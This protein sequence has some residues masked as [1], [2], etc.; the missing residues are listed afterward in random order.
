MVEYDE[1]QI[2]SLTGELEE[3]EHRALEPDRSRISLFATIGVL[4]VTILATL[5]A[6]IAA[7]FAYDEAIANRNRQL[8]D[9]YSLARTVQEDSTS[10]NMLDAGNAQSAAYWRAV[11]TETLAAGASTSAERSALQLQATSYAHDANESQPPRPIEPVHAVMPGGN[12]CSRFK[13]PGSGVGQ[14]GTQ[15]DC[16]AE[17]AAAY[18]ETA[19]GFLRNE[20]TFL[21]IASA[22]AISLFLFALS[23]TLLIVPMQVMFLCVGALT[24]LGS[25][26]IGV[27]ELAWRTASQPD[28]A[29]ISAYEN[30][31]FAQAVQLDPGYVDA[32]VG[33]SQFANDCTHAVQAAVEAE[34]LS[35]TNINKSD[36]ATTEMN[37][38]HLKS[39]RTQ[40]LAA[41]RD[42]AAKSDPWPF[43]SAVE[44]LL[45]NGDPKL[46]DQAL[47]QAIHY[48][49][50]ISATNGTKQ[51]GWVYEDLWFSSLLSNPID[52]LQPKW[53]PPFI[54]RV[55][56]AEAALAE[57]E[58]EPNTKLSGRPLTGVAITDVTGQIG[59]FCC[60]DP[61]PSSARSTTLSTV[62]AFVEPAG[63]RPPKGMALDTP[64]RVSFH[65]SGLEPG[66][67][68][69]LMWYSN[70]NGDQ[71]STSDVAE[72]F[73]TVG[74]TGAPDAGTG[75]YTTPGWIFAP[76]GSY[77]L[78]I[79]VNSTLEAQATMNVPAFSG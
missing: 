53:G 58:A 16:A 65:F 62:P 43:G 79:V 73:A 57:Q 32:W 28:A 24:A 61:S 68:V 13:T 5:S 9:S 37:C 51:R 27:Y 59:T 19:A 36:L 23:R 45:V 40:L 1:E 22:L 25:V 71:N 70:Q 3:A 64:V 8:W 78:A 11:F 42:P 60:T 38:G 10:N 44:W 46:A 72:T 31:R 2:T 69:T 76:N 77:R 35:P 18:G 15:S 33:R 41:L 63:L 54:D 56:G 14:I 67:V 12:E 7:V 26:G 29:A 21:A 47:G 49:R 48:M 74:T 66:D 6:T 30:G 34:Q 20:R 39:A 4:V 55:E 17:F 50:N 75:S 52:K